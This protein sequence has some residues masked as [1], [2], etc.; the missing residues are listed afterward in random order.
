M[1]AVGAVLERLVEVGL[2]ALDLLMIERSF[3][4]LV[5]LISMFL[6]VAK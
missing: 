1:F 2:V 5:G 6:N 4:G 3:L